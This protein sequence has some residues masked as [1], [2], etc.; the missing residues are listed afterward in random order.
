MLLPINPVTEVKLVFQVN[1]KHR[2]D[3]LVP[4]GLSQD[5]AVAIA[6]SQSKVAPYLEGKTIARI[7]YVPGKILN[8]VVP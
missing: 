8:L 3:Q 1:G 2:G 6:R 7:I 4:I 5:E